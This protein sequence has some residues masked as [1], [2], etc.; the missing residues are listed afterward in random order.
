VLRNGLCA[1]CRS[2]AEPPPPPNDEVVV[3]DYDER[4]IRQT[5]DPI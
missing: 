2:A 4:K 5:G 3:R 1:D